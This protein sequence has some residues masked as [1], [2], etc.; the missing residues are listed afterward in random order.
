MKLGVPI[1]LDHWKFHWE[2]PWLYGEQS[3]LLASTIAELKTQIFIYD[4]IRSGRQLS[5]IL[6]QGN[7]EDLGKRA[8]KLQ[9][10]DT[11][12]SM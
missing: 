4:N 10:G 11:L 6:P 2:H 3:E 1:K 12:L 9:V 5:S 7:H 8:T